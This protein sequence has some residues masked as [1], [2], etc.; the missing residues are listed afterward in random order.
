MGPG[1][2]SLP[3]RFGDFITVTLKLN[4]GTIEKLQEWKTIKSDESRNITEDELQLDLED[5]EIAIEL[6]EKEKRI[7]E[8]SDVEGS[9]GIWLDLNK[10]NLEKLKKVIENMGP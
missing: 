5:R 2:E 7:L 3:G 10:E 6:H 8:I 4:K 1:F 9:F